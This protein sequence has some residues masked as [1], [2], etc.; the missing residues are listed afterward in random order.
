MGFRP[1]PAQFFQFFP[2]EMPKIPSDNVIV[3]VFLI[4]IL[5]LIVNVRD[6]R[7]VQLSAQ[8]Q[9][10]VVNVPYGKELIRRK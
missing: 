10:L 1:I 3:E 4:R 2:W 7:G 6:N 5:R 8:F 9:A